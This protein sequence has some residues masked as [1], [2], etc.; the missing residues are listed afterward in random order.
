MELFTT[1]GN[2]IDE[3]LERR[4]QEEVKKQKEKI[5][6]EQQALAAEERRIQASED[7]AK[8]KR[9]RLE[10]YGIKK[11]GGVLRYPAEALTEHTDYLQIDIERYEAIGDNYITS[12]GS[13]GR[14]V[15]GTAKQ[16]R[17]GK[18]SSKKLAK[19]PLINLGSILLPIPANI[20]D[21][22]NVVYGDSTLNG[23][24]AAGVS[25]VETGMTTLG[26]AIAGTGNVDLGAMK[27]DIS[28][29]IEAGLGGG[30]KETALAT[31]SDIVTKKL[32]SEAVNIFGQ[33]VTT[34]QLL[35]RN[36]GE[37][38]NPNMELLFSDV[39]IRNFRF[40]FKLTPRNPKEAEQIKLIIR[41][42]KRNM[43][44]Q[45][46]GGVQ[47]AGN[48]LLRA[49]NIFK[50]RY[51]SGTKD[52][53]F[54]NKFKQCFLTGVQTTYTGEGVYSTYDDRTPVSIILDL[55]F[56]EIQPIYDIDY[57]TTPGNRAV[58]Y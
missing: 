51:R 22:N 32:I 1:L 7:R 5:K 9:K 44:P 36:T 29:K 55:S 40:N 56:K 23:L 10:K 52:H 42:F 58:G 53:P 34:Q 27:S 11:Q 2:R 33:N 43:A 38:L 47:G 8:I 13:S 16:N 46:Q 3:E 54:L 30:D 21:S 41:A 31:A 35:S 57:D 45:A 19:K 26:Q 50:L 20:E 24:A 49:P 28:N 39:T 6:K 37:I 15:V 18:T 14:Y 25:A 12:T 17:A 4:E 48:F